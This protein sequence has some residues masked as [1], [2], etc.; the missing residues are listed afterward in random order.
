MFPVI[1][2][3]GPNRVN[4]RYF[5]SGRHEFTSKL[6][7][8]KLVIANLM[9]LPANER[10]EAILT[11]AI[12]LFADKGFRGTT[13]RELAAA[14]GVSEPVIYQHFATK[15]DLYEAILER[16]SQKTNK[17]GVWP[18]P[19]SDVET[20]LALGKLIWSWYEQD[21]TLSRLLFFSALE[22]H[23]L[24]DLFF[25]RHARGFIEQISNHIR[26]RIAD[27][28]FRPVDP[29]TLAMCFIGQVAYDAQSVTMFHFDPKQA[30]R[31]QVLK[32][33]VELFLRGVLIHPEPIGA[34]N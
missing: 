16:Q 21:R 4:R 30:S 28:A 17:L 10:R 34:S 33:M 29:D 11:K 8:A 9:R 14:V 22:G 18:E 26:Q 3:G 19:G 25:A 27:G 24:S 7:N 13:T 5:E 32:D 31:E 15:R 23:E 6:A 2:S 12:Q 1:G 20:F